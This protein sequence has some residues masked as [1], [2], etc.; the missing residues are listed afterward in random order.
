MNF[1][2]L[3]I[4]IG[5][6]WPLAPA[7]LVFLFMTRK[8]IFKWFMAGVYKRLNNVA[9]L[10]NMLNSLNTLSTLGSGVAGFIGISADNNLTTI[11]AVGFFFAG[12]HGS[13]A[14][15]MRLERVKTAQAADA[16]M[17]VAKTLRADRDQGA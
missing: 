12:H 5:G 9:W 7:L 15:R 17:E 8:P 14:I 2:I 4:L 13:Y 10:E 6:L 11:L 3:L 1:Q 16:L